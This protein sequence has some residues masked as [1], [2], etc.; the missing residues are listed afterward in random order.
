MGIEDFIAANTAALDANTKALTAA[1]QANATASAPKAAAATGDAGSAG[2]KGGRP[3]KETAAQKKKR[4]AAERKAAEDELAAAAGADEEEEEDEKGEDIAPRK[5]ITIK[6]LGKIMGD[7]MD[8]EDEDVA[9]AREEQVVAAFDHLGVSSLG[10]IT[11][12]DELRQLALYV[13]N[14]V[15]GNDVDFD[16]LDELVQGEDVA[17]KTP[18]KKKKK[19]LL[20]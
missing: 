13:D 12:A 3:P 9:E 18:A 2:A 17:P 16:A 11:D 5:S 4:E 6:A 7:W 19:S 14:W 15:A 1:L 8:V 10:E 20:G